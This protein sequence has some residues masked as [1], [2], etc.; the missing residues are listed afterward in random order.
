MINT[1]FINLKYFLSIC[2]TSRA[3]LYE[4]RLNLTRGYT[5]LVRVSHKY[6][7]YRN[8]NR[9]KFRLKV[10]IKETIFYLQVTKLTI[11]QI[12]TCKSSLIVKP[13]KPGIYDRVSFF[14][15][16]VQDILLLSNSGGSSH[17]N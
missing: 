9:V 8:P 15:L 13:W 14:Y 12:L 5:Y 6:N 17:K 10:F 11:S 3:L 16:E 1:L 7:P 2:D 4:I